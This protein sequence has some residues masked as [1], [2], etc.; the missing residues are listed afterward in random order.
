MARRRAA[1]Q[2]NLIAG[3]IYAQ[4]ITAMVETGL[5]DYLA[6]DVRSIE[7]IAAHC[8]F[9][10]AAADRL[11]RAARSLQL[12]ESPVDNGWTLGMAGAPLSS[13]DGAI[14]MIRHHHLLYQDLADPLAL[15]RDDRQ[16]ETNLSAFWTYAAKDNDARSAADYSALMAATQPMVCEQIVD[17]Y[18]FDKHQRM[19]DIGGGSGAF[20]AAVH[21]VAPDLGLGIFDLPDVMPSTHDRLA[22][23]GL[24]DS[25]TAHAGSF[26]TDPLPS[27][28][29][30]ITLIR[31]LHDHDDAVIMPLLAKIH[32][33]LPVNGRLL[34]VEPMAE[35]RGAEAMGDGY[36]GLYLWAMRSGRPRSATENTQMLKNAGFSKVR[37][38]KTAQPLITKALVADK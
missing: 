2:F 7:D 6:Q 11:M 22:A 10:H 15:L 18:R 16:A 32:A 21:H 14:A 26:K 29:D 28:Y 38:I 33:A 27:G 31:I 36:F 24:T 8:Q 34:I 35:T 1:H 20:A 3:F 19:L 17:G 25:V 9:S 37:N 4:V 30:L 23:M 5:L 12:V 13:N